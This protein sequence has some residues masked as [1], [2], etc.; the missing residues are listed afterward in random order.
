VQ[1]V[2]CTLGAFEEGLTDSDIELIKEQVEELI[3][4]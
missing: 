1:I 3:G 4:T 2:N